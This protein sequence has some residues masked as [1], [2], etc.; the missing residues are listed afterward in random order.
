MLLFS[1]LETVQIFTGA[2]KIGGGSGPKRWLTIGGA[3]EVDHAGA[4]F[5]LV[6]FE[7]LDG[8]EI[9][10]GRCLVRCCRRGL[11]FS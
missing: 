3:F 4:G 10:V 6:F 1:V 7:F 11:S 2:M 5:D 9:K 8:L